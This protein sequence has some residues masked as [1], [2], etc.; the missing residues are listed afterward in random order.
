MSAHYRD[1]YDSVK[2]EVDENYAI[3]AIYSYGDHPDADL[4]VRV[5]GLSHKPL[6]PEYYHSFRSLE[7]KIS[8]I[9]GQLDNQEKRIEE[10]ES[11]I[12]NIKKEINQSIL[13]K[14]TIKKSESYNKFLQEQIEILKIKKLYPE[15]ILAFTKKGDKLKLVAHAITYKELQKLISQ[16]RRKNMISKE[17][18][19][20]YQ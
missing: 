6:Y 8:Y 2:N 4:L 17:D 14:P 19:I 18:E 12:I 20:F 9:E 1:T 11:I 15:N 5:I 13:I 16:A 10:I 7:D 3:M